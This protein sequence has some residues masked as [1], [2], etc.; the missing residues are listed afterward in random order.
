MAIVGK[1]GKSQ[2]KKSD[3]LSKISKSGW[4][5]PVSH[6]SHITITASY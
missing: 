2:H 5:V 6:D 4:S 1:K 3:S